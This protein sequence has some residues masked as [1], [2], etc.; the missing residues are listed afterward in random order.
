MRVSLVAQRVVSVAQAERPCA[1]EISNRVYWLGMAGIVP[2]IPSA[3]QFMQIV[4]GV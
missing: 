1:T 3:N 2:W 4:H